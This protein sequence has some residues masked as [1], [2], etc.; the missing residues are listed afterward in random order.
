MEWRPADGGNPA[1][2]L[3]AF[4][5]GTGL[6]TPQSAEH[7][8]VAVTVLVGAAGCAALAGLP[9]PA[10]SPVDV[11]ELVAVAV[12][13][14]GEPAPA[15]TAPVLGEWRTSWT[16]AEHADA[17]SAVRQAI[18]RGD[19]YQA[20]VVGHRSAPHRSDPY[21]VARAV[22]DVPAAYGGLLTG[23]GW[24]VGCASPEQL[25]RTRGRRITTEPIKGT[26]R[27][28]E[29]LR[30]SA[31]DRAEHVMIVDLERNDLAR[32]AVTGSVQVERLYELQDWNGLWH[33]HS[34]VA[35][36]LREGATVLD[37]L[38]AVAP[39]GSV[40]GAPKRAATQLLAGL[41]PVGRGP[42]MGAFGFVW[43]GGMDLG[44]TIRTVA[45]D[46]DSVHLWAGGGITWGSDPEQEVAEAHAKA[47][48]VLRAL[49]PA[50]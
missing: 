32:V 37:V 26:S 22:A 17:V 6:T 48:P 38:R 12:E 30:V 34:T 18:A 39:G 36:E 25:V 45:A 49:G 27:D 24:A 7:G 1:A 21:D 23:E 8:D 44:L 14:S 9:L 41:E 28:R 35:A 19:V 13:R 20:N 42:A 4:L 16:D 47:E 46:E 43:A 15:A 40:T 10:P 11:P 29:Q 3:T 33:A 5:D 31:K 2:L 50:L